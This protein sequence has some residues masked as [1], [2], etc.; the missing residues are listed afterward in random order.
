MAGGV[1]TEPET[2]RSQDLPSAATVQPRQ[3]R[4]V[5]VRFLLALVR[6]WSPLLLLIVL[7]VV[8]SFAT[9]NF[10][11]VTNWQT[12]LVTQAVVAC[13]A[14]GSLFPLVIGEFDLSLGAML[15]LV[16]MVGAFVGGKG[17]GALV[18]VVVMLGVGIL[19]GFVNGF[20]TV[21]LKVSSF[22]ATL[23]VS[24]VIGG[25]TLGVSGGQVLFIGIPKFVV[26]LG[27]QRAGG[28]ALCVWI[29]L[30]IAAVM[31]FVLTQTPT[32]RRL[33]AI[34]ANQRVAYLAGVRTQQLRLLAFVGAGLLVAVGAI[35]ELG[36]AGGANPSTGPDLLLPAYAAAFLGAVS[37]KIGFYN[38]PGTLIAIV[39]LAVGFNGLSLLG[40]PSWVQPVFN[41]CVL[42][43]AVLSARAESKRVT[44]S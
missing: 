33:Y 37:Y 30:G 15:G 17:H 36:Q 9:P 34:G 44:V 12:I 10:M 35:F 40:V 28:V 5:V 25:I 8:F 3:A 42:L 32:G 7:I 38:V 1:S 18:D 14:L 23:A 22:V 39:L 20:L 21:V 2:E 4:P 11:T 19:V 43:I 16:A 41:G 6:R 24:I 29:T 13:I 27:Q 31:M 26:D